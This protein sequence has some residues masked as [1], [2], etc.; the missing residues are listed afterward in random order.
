MSDRQVVTLWISVAVLL[1]VFSL[2]GVVD[3]GT[4]AAG[5][6]AEF[7]VGNVGLS[8]DAID[9]GGTAKL[10]ADVTNVGD[11]EGTFIAEFRV[12]G[13]VRDSEEVTLLGGDSTAV[14]LSA[15]FEESGKYDVQFTDA[16]AGTLTVSEPTVAEFDVSNA[17]F[18]NETVLEGETATVSADVTNVGDAEGTF[19]AELEVGDSTNGGDRETVSVDPGETRTVDLGE[20]FEETGRYR[21][22]VSGEPA[23]TLTVEKPADPKVADAILQETE[24][25]EGGSVGVLVILENAGDRAGDLDV[26]LTSDGP[27]ELTEN[28]SVPP[29]EDQTTLDPTFD[30]AGEYRIAVNGVGAGTLTVTAPPDPEVTNAT[31]DPEVILV[32][33][34]VDI[35]ATVGNDG[36]RNGG[37]VVDSEI[38]GETDRKRTVSVDGGGS[39]NVTFTKRFD[40]P[41]EYAVSVNGVDAGTVVVET[42][43]DPE[44]TDATIPV[45]SVL[46]NESVD[47]SGVVENGG[48]RDGEMVV[49]LAIDGDVSDNRTVAVAGGGSTNVSFTTS[50]DEAGEYNVSIAGVGAGTV[51]VETPADPRITG[52][53]L[54]STE[55]V[56]GGSVEVSATIENPGDR[57]GEMDIE[58][59][60]DGNVT[61]ERTVAVAGGGSTNVSMNETF[62]TS[63]EYNVSVSGTDAGVLTVEVDDDAS[64]GYSGSSVSSGP[65][66]ISGSSGSTGSPGSP[67]SSEPSGSSETD[68]DADPPDVEPSLNRTET[69]DEVTVRVDDAGNG[70]VVV[71]VDLSGPSETSPDV[72]V[73]T[74]EVRP[75]GDRGGFHVRAARPTTDPGDFPAAPRG[76]VLAY[77]DLGSNLAANETSESTLHFELDSAAL[78]DGTGTDDVQVMQYVDG[79]WTTVGVTH[80]VDGSSHSVGLPDVTPLAVVS[81]EPGSVEIVD[82]D[83]P[84]W[85]RT[86]YETSVSATV[87][88]TGKR[89]VTRTLVV[90][91]DGEAVAERDVSVEPGETAAVDIA[92]EPTDGGT[93]TLDGV[94]VGEL[95]V[96]DSR[97]GSAP[98]SDGSDSTDD[99]PGFGPITA[100]IALLVAAL[101][102]R[103]RRS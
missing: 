64:G 73:S 13:E 66:G 57:D 36:G 53:A 100:I 43:A 68:D 16:D 87:R 47:I 55:I 80:G 9:Q 94:E 70:S 78:P 77:V 26:E 52:A 30:E 31:V 85:V 44:V 95:S 101:A 22:A 58:L 41:G 89:T 19:T 38:D 28:V 6:T 29:G 98:S 12:N 72:S 97:G 88:N 82:A 20:T 23:G 75:E 63:G 32:G 90:S 54:E 59:A 92:F 14:T 15:V 76:T 71:P 93:V 39:E 7:E 1:S 48:D 84:D 37:L 42:P 11:A 34:S 102:A 79:E 24:I 96:G 103:I 21:I 5:N 67:G 83:V 86:G 8:D 18:A 33:D 51:G 40:R 50:F 45:D 62:D 91:I 65:S 17:R 3:G 35:T 61:D 25:P 81:I 10:S 99:I 69:A 56:E 74:L 4:A 46:V 27:V 49:E 60:V 2:G